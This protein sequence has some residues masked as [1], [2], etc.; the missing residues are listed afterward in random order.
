VLAAAESLGKHQLETTCLIG[1]KESEGKK[2]IVEFKSKHASFEERG[3]RLAVLY[4]IGNKLREER[5]QVEIELPKKQSQIEQLNKQLAET[6]RTLTMQ[7]WR[8]R[9]KNLPSERILP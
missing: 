6:P 2:Q 9:I 3:G 1:D 4:N 7:K 8:L 5:P